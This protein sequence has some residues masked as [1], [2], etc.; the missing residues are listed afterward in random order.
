M[1]KKNMT[2]WALIGLAVG[3]LPALH[4]DGDGL[5]AV[6][7][8]PAMFANDS[9]GTYAAERRVRTNRPDDTSRS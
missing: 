9:L 5:V 4:L 7:A 6:T 1:F 3:E 8:S 2:D